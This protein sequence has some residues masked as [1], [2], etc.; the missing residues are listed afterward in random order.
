MATLWLVQSHLEGVDSER[1]VEGWL[2]QHFP[3]VTE[4]Y[5]AGIQVTGYALRHRFEKMPPLADSASWVDVELAPGL[6]LLACEVTTPLVAASDFRMHPPSGWVHVRLWW[7]AT[8]AVE[9]AYMPDVQLVGP[10]GVW[11]ERLYRDGE[12][13]RRDPTSQWPV[14]SVVRDEVDV[15]LNPATPPG[16]YPLQ[17]RLRDLAGQEVGEQVACGS[18]RVVSP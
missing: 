18:A 6:R 10:E 5:P 16:S 1:V 3:V 14:G 11:G 8:A 15:N 4:Q 7:Q 13:L 12:I 2:D 17:V 9:Q